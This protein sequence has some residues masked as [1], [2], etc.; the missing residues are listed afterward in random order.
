VC[1]ILFYYATGL[2][3][4]FFLFL[5]PPSQKKWPTEADQVG[6][7]NNKRSAV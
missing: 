4:I 7:S 5:Y 2:E 3:K 1:Q 6:S